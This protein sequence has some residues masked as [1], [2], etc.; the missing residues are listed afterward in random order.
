[1]QCHAE[2]GTTQQFPPLANAAI[3][4]ASGSFPHHANHRSAGREGGLSNVSR[5]GCIRW[6]HLRSKTLRVALPQAERMMETK[7]DRVSKPHPDNR[8]SCAAVRMG[9]SAGG[10]A[11][12]CTG[13]W[14][15]GWAGSAEEEIGGG[16]GGRVGR[17]RGGRNGGQGAGVG[18]GG[19]EVGEWGLGIGGWGWGLYWFILSRCAAGSRELVGDKQHRGYSGGAG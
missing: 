8:S 10:P 18:E 3:F 17:N 19:L 5:A 16:G 1:M 9:L 7:V 2:P 14:V 15:G 13:R 4:S 6:Q 12:G 11:C